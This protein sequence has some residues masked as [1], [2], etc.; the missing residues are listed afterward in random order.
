[1]LGG[2]CLARV[3]YF[4]LTGKLIVFDPHFFFKILLPPIIFKSGF[5]IKLDLFF[6]NFTTIMLFANV[7][8]VINILVVC[9]VMIMAY[10]THSSPALSVSESLVFGSVVS[11]TDPVTTVV[12]FERLRVEE[13]LYV[14]VVGVSILDDA[15]SVIVFHLF[16]KYVT[17]GV[18]TVPE[19]LIAVIFFFAKLIGS[20]CLGYG[21]GVLFCCYL[22]QFKTLF[23]PSPSSDTAAS[24]PLLLW[25]GFFM[26]IYCSYSIA[27]A[28]YLSGIISALFAGVSVN[29]YL[30]VLLQD[31]QTSSQTIRSL[32]EFVGTWASIVEALLFFYM[33]SSMFNDS[34]K[35]MVDV[36]FFLWSN[37]AFI[38]GRVAQIYPLSYLLNRYRTTS[39]SGISESS[40]SSWLSHDG[41]ALP[42]TWQ[43]MIFFAGLRGPIAFAS[44]VLYPT[45]A[46]VSS[47]SI[48]SVT[49]LTVFLSTFLLGALTPTAL[50]HFNIPRDG[51]AVPLSLES[52]GRNNYFPTRQTTPPSRALVVM[53]AEDDVEEATAGDIDGK[54]TPDLVPPSRLM[55]WLTQL[56][57]WVK[58]YLSRPPVELT[59]QRDGG[60][61]IARMSP[62][63][64][65][66]SSEL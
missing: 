61:T 46:S 53:I 17:E 41:V 37:F 11:A 29:K 12:V 55:T 3:F 51:A 5:D 4:P 33:G 34:F 9:F 60:H 43:H 38:L 56:D 19:I 31:Q 1:M 25:L 36:G 42:M 62:M 48:R 45:N 28:A 7:G 40:A 59:A 32:R 54:K 26:F 10:F 50:A 58:I 64:R 65:I 52:I 20:M 6:K 57:N 8:T 23:F 13:N 16:S 24:P 66:P 2:V 14:I 49:G 22:R 35:S 63:H 44:A 39:Q 30:P 18:I 47:G 27:D 15:I 21:L